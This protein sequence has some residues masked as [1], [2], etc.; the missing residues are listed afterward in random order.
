MSQIQSQE[1]SWLLLEQYVFSVIHSV[2]NIDCQGISEHIICLE[3][4]FCCMLLM[5][6][7][8]E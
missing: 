5:K 7:E 1:D 8:C 3:Q 4:T 6:Y 2:A